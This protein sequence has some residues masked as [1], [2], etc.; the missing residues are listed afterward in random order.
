[1]VVAL[2]DALA[3]LPASGWACQQVGRASTGFSVDP[4]GASLDVA[5]KL[6]VCVHCVFLST[7][8][9]RQASFCA[10]RWGCSQNTTVEKTKTRPLCITKSSPRAW[11][12]AFRSSAPS[13][14]AR[15]LPR[16]TE[17]LQGSLRLGRECLPS[18]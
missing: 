12:L 9:S 16:A 13:L 1:M 18:Q 8:N 7:I 3:C 10:K 17:A 11:Q 2:M 4:V 14:S 15:P 6:W 5:L